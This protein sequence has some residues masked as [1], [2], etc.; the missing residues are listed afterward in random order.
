MKA[1][2]ALAALVL[3]CATAGCATVP[4][5][6][7]TVVL[8][9]PAQGADLLRQCSRSGPL[10]GHSFFAPRPREITAVETA[11]ARA[12]E[13]ARHRYRDRPADALAAFAWPSDPS[14]YNRQYVGYVADGRRKIYGNFVPRT[15]GPSSARPTVI[16]DGGPSLF[17]VEY[18]L[19]A[20]RVDRIAFNAGLGGPFFEDIVPE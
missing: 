6:R 11:S 2:E 3:A 13:A 16:C 20:D 15:F 7:E 1:T 17:G 10:A 4:I 12:L 5:A 18:D 19:L 8:I 14:L 9:E